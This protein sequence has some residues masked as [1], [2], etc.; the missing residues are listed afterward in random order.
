MRTKR[1]VLDE[2]QR[3]RDEELARYLG[4]PVEGVL[5]CAIDDKFG[6][7]VH[8]GSDFRA[9]SYNFLYERIGEVKPAHVLRTLSRFNIV[10]RRDLLIGAMG[11]IRDARG[12]RVLDFGCGTG[13]HGLYF[14]QRGAA[15][16]DF[17]D[18]P[19]PVYDFARWRVA[20][21]G[22]E[23]RA[24]FF[25]P[26]SE[27]PGGRYDVVLCVDVLEHT[28][29]PP[30]EFRK[31]LAA[32]RKGAFILLQ[33]GDYLNPRQGHF[34]QSK[35]RWRSRKNWAFIKESLRSLAGPARRSYY[36]AKR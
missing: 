29:D 34:R 17:L 25:R 11:H 30:A 9:R 24:R 28:A 22:F 5:E 12:L 21:R 35:E 14:L 18:V 1:T 13:G 36:F 6:P 32:T 20:D 3:Q 23:D 27:L 33:Y 26:E 19:G 8:G 15:S 31:I 4:I 10:K 2:T 7:E 16:V